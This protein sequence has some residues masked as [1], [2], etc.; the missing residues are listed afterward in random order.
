MPEPVTTTAALL[1]GYC[2][3]M[4]ELLLYGT[5]TSDSL[6]YGN[7]DHYCQVTENSNSV[8]TAPVQRFCLKYFMLYTRTHSV[9]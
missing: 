4:V 5:S 8:W 9:R 2:L 1:K 3:S 6:F 7:V